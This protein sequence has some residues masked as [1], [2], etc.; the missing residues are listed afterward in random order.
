MRGNGLYCTGSDSVFGIGA[1]NRRSGAYWSV[2]V[3]LFLELFAAS[4]SYLENPRRRDRTDADPVS[5]EPVVGATDRRLQLSRSLCRL[6]QPV[7]SWVPTSWVHS[8]LLRM[9]LSL[10]I[11]P[12]RILGDTKAGRAFFK[13]SDRSR[14]SHAYSLSNRSNMTGCGP[15]IRS[16]HWPRTQKQAPTTVRTDLS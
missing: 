11:V 13:V 6:N 14:W 2:F 8:W 4:S 12:R 10:Q 7:K 16:A 15:C 1:W 9:R 5:P 3:A